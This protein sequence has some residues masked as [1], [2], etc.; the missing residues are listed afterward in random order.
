MKIEKFVFIFIGL[1][2]KTVCT[3][4]NFMSVHTDFEIGTYRQNQF[5]CFFVDIL[6]LLRFVKSVQII[7][8]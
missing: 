6:F 1:I 7:E 2:V 4:L 5:R 3:D 8:K